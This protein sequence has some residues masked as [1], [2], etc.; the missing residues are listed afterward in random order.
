M[1]QGSENTAYLMSSGKE[2]THESKLRPFVT[3]RVPKFLLVV[4]YGNKHGSWYISDSHG[5]ETYVR[6]RV[7]LKF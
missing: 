5:S 3:C 2:H 4:R 7:N 1:L 6:Y